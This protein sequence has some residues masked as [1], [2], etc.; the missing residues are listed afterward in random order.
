MVSVLVL[1]IIQLIQLC[2]IIQLIQLCHI[3]Q[4][5]QLCLIIQLIQLCLII[6]LC[7]SFVYLVSSNAT[8]PYPQICNVQNTQISRIFMPIFKKAIWVCS[9]LRFA[10]VR[11]SLLQCVINRKFMLR[12]KATLLLVTSDNLHLTST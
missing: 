8:E 1:I 3:I 10:A 4:L 9:V 6:Q 12:A 11:C 2:L 5:I 7:L